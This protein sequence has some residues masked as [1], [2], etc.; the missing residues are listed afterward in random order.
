MKKKIKCAVIG[1]GTWGYN[2][3]LI[4]N[5]GIYS[6]L[7]AVCDIDTN[8]AKAF[9][10]KF[11]TNYY[12]DLEKMFKSEDIETIGIATPDFAHL[13]P[14]LT[15]IA[16]NKSIICEKPLVIKPDDLD[17]V[18]SAVN[19]H[20]VRIMVDYHMRYIP[21]FVV[22][23]D[24][25]NEGGLGKPINIYMRQND[26]ISFAAG[27]SNWSTSW[28]AKS[29]VL[30]FL[31]SHTVD[32]VSWFFND[33]IK[34][35]FSVSHEGILKEKGVDTAD[36]YLTTLEFEGGGIAQI[37][38]G[39]I[40]P[41]GNPSIPDVKVNILCSKGLINMDLTSSNYLN[42][43]TENRIVNPDFWITP[44]YYDSVYGFAFESIRD[45]IRK[46]YLDE[47]FRISFDS[48]VNTNKVLFSIFESAKK[49]EPV[50]VIY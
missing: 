39:W 30:W 14:L 23:K 13:E 36:N 47:D 22:S 12:T 6:E 44:K 38:N 40:T 45:G 5:E 9:S 1:C 35:V 4:F 18:V 15:A 46:L 2:M 29:S 33:K 16:Y 24:Q 3:A 26:A 41:N 7:V 17:A 50:K 42:I 28:A 37:E 8:K 19:K 49:R 27:E 48:S 10:K 20:K 21:A 34:R 31:G 32:A 25:I 11:K 43:W